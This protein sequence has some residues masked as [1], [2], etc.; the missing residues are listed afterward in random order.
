[1]W[2]L[3]TS[4]RLRS[5][6]G[7]AL[8]LPRAACTACATRASARA[9]R[10]DHT[11]AVLPPAGGPAARCGPARRPPPPR[12]VQLAPDDACRIRRDAFLD[13]CAHRPRTIVDVDR[14]ASAE[15]ARPPAPRAPVP[16]TGDAPAPSWCANPPPPAAVPPRC[17]RPTI[18]ERLRSRLPESSSDRRIHTSTTSSKAGKC[19]KSTTGGL[20]SVLRSKQQLKAAG[21]GRV[22]V[23]SE[24]GCKEK[25]ATGGRLELSVP[26]GT[27]RV[28]VRVSLE[29]ATGGS[30][31][32]VPDSEL[33]TISCTP[34]RKD[35]STFCAKASTTSVRQD[36]WLSNKFSKKYQ[37][38]AVRA[39]PAAPPAD[40]TR[41]CS[42]TSALLA[43]TVVVNSV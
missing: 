11:Y 34:V 21:L 8:P 23:D 16:K 2:S 29:G 18:V 30:C 27:Q 20:E 37:T 15:P 10:T 31:H 25:K 24:A 43:N 33:S 42:S 38:D 41:R 14:S 17:R 39:P 9:P 4:G 28:A 35:N 7:A 19:A 13:P 22:V 3:S 1:M 26:A 40:A 12:C 6:R 5:A 32:A 36:S